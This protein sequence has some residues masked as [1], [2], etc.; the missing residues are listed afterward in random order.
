MNTPSVPWNVQAPQLH[1]AACRAVMEARAATQKV[2]I[3]SECIAPGDQVRSPT[4]IETLELKNPLDTSRCNK[5]YTC[6]DI[7]VPHMHRAIQTAHMISSSSVEESDMESVNISS[8][9]ESDDGWSIISDRSDFV[10]IDSAETTHHHSDTKSRKRSAPPKRVSKL[11]ERLRTSKI[12]PQ[13]T[14]PTQNEQGMPKMK[15]A[16]DKGSQGDDE[17]T[18]R[19]VAPKPNGN[20]IDE[21]IERL[22]EQARNL[23]L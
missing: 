22:T 5:G 21:L 8:D 19:L 13:K 14:I 20:V 9:N 16:A 12:R 17:H 11:H 4:G 3:N 7:K 18:P 10:V 2:S 15:P 23:K 1:Q 6:T